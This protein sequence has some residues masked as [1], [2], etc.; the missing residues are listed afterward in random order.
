MEASGELSPEE[1]FSA[2][3]RSYWLCRCEGF[4]VATHDGRQVGLVEG[5]RFSSP[6]RLDALAVRCGDLTLVPVEAIQ[7]IRPLEERVILAARA[8]ALL[9]GG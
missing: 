6:D 9:G 5:L 3:D 8:A 2:F 1:A 4:R 7:E